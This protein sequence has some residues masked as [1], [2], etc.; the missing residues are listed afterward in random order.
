MI[1]CLKNYLNLS[2]LL[3]QILETR[4][5]VNEVLFLRVVTFVPRGV[6]TEDPWKWGPQVLL[7]NSSPLILSRIIFLEFNKIF[8]RP[9][10]TLTSQFA[11]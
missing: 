4:I 6:R 9:L 1:N 2:G 10:I 8:F 3:L 7:E 11:H 5:L